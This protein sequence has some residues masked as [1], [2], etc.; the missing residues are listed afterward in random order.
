[1]GEAESNRGELFKIWRN[2]DSADDPIGYMGDFY[3]P[4]G[5]PVFVPS[6]LAELGFPPGEY[7]VR[8]P[9]SRR[10]RLFPKWQKLR[11]RN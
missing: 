8:I 7:T 11:V 5:R 6:D 10:R 2:P 1:M 9:E 3:P 4:N